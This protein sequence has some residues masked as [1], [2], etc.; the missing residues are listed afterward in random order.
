M[1]ILWLD[2]KP[3]STHY[4]RDLIKKNNS[5][6]KILPFK[7]IGKLLAYLDDGNNSLDANNTIFIIDVMLVGEWQFT[8][9]DKTIPI[10]EE[11]MAGVEFYENFLEK[12]YPTIPTILY[13]SRGGGDGI[14]FKRFVENNKYNKTL[15]IIGKEEF[16]TEF[17][18]SIKNLG[19]KVW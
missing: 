4:E 19:V 14:I 8:F 9:D 17:K 10:H 15:F 18:S 11:L 7:L 1:T 13:T 6:I 5:D 12:K 3:D 2:D 16:E